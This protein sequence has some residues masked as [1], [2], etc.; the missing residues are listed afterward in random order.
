[1]WNF[2]ALKAFESSKHNL[3]GAFTKNWRSSTLHSS[4]YES[5]AENLVWLSLKNNEMSAATK[6]K[7]SI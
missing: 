2:K 7:S 6:E 5:H 1:M 3:I 4:F